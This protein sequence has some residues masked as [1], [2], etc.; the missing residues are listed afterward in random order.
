[1]TKEPQGAHFGDYLLAGA[2]TC[3]AGFIGVVG[4]ALCATVIGFPVGIP[5]LMLAG[6][7]GASAWKRIFKKSDLRNEFV[8][9]Q[10][11]QE[12]RHRKNQE[13]LDNVTA[14]PDEELPWMI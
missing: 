12:A 5:L 1:M 10:R 14:V 3:F 7:I 2:A 13:D 9:Y 11:D 6:K 4:L 8:N